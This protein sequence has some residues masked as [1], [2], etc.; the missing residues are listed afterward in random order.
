MAE[1]Q[2]GEFCWNE[3]AASN[4]KAAKDFY[5]KVFG[6]TYTELPMPDTVY[7]VIQLNGKDIG[8][9]WAIP[10]DKQGTIQPHWVTYIMVDDIE[11]A[12]KKAHDNGAKIVKPASPAGDIGIFAIIEDPTGAHIAFWEPLKEF[13]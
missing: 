6:W 2:N 5:S 9:I 1:K 3:L 11:A 13:H 8:G 10:K 12:L 4:V 7:T